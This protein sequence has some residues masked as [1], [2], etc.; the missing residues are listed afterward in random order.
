M[1][2]T[3]S[4]FFL[5]SSYTLTSTAS[6]PDWSSSATLPGEKKC[7][8]SHHGREVCLSAGN[9]E[10]IYK[11]NKDELS[12]S[13][14]RGARYALDYPVEASELRL[15]LK[16]MDKFFESDSR[17]LLRRFIYKIAKNISNFQSFDDLFNWMGLHKYPTHSTRQRG[18]NLIPNMGELE[19]YPMGV[20]I[21]HKNSQSPSMT[22]SCAAC[23]SGNLFG[24]K[25]LG[26]TNRFPK[27][28]ETFILGKKA[29]LT[30]NPLLFNIMVGPSKADMTTYKVS[31]NAIKYVEVKAPMAVGLDTSLAQVALSLSLRAQDEFASRIPKT[32]ARS[33]PLD[34]KP[35][36]SKPAV[37]WNLKYKTKW[38]SD[39]SINSGNPIHTNFLWNEIGRGVDLNKLDLWLDNNKQKVKDLT[40]Y[41]F[42]T[43]A[44]LYDNF[45]PNQIKIE[46]AMR[47]EKLFLKSC[48]GCHGV[49]EK[50]WEDSNLSF[51]EKIQTSKT[52]YHT[53]T[54]TKNVGT[55]P[56]RFDGMK[57]FAKDLNRLKISKKIGTVVIPQKGY[58]PPPLV[59]I[60]A[61]W[62]YFH[63]NSA[64]T[65]YDVLSPDSK[66]PTFYIATPALDKKLD[67]DSIKNGYPAPEYIREKYRLNKDYHFNTSTDGLS[68]SGHTRM[69]LDSDGNDKFSHSEKLEIIEY[70]KTL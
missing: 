34:S 8:V 40:A 18:P 51:S 6:N 19:K 41:V 67:F 24:T 57:Y 54:I 5:V 26:M 61:R 46:T 37:W 65:L 42:Q 39:A 35:A 27:A 10:N 23:H 36:D 30:S 28:N 53:K 58:V 25:V 62:P 22:F 14:E 32:K 63:N 12:K 17:S 43:K 15:P 33:N 50:R 31:R 2:K 9:R 3:L 48:S 59:G 11:L 21:F 68:N 44:P 29:L 47:G 38:L 66:R 70:L 69:M 45:F 4:L 16:A 1:I 49:Y 60:W 13:I 55:D 52:W 7:F 56:H 64:P 20:S